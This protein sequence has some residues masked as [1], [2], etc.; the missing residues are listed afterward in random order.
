MIHPHLIEPKRRTGTHLPGP[1]TSV[2]EA[3][4]EHQT[5]STKEVT[6]EF[7]PKEEPHRISQPNMPDNSLLQTLLSRASAPITT[8][9]SQ[10]GSA[11]SE[12]LNNKG[13]GKTGALAEGV[14]NTL[15]DFTSPI[16]LA[17]MGLGPMIGRAA[18]GLLGGA[19]APVGEGAS[20]LMPSVTNFGKIPIPSVI[21]KAAKV[22]ET[23]GEMSPEFTPVGAEEM[24]GLVKP[25]IGSSGIDPL[26][27]VLKQKWAPLLTK[28]GVK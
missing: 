24:Y 3:L 10:V 27:E 2:Q 9:P 11:A 15:S 5:P 6:L 18:S 12:A 21:N 7:G 20:K 14:G 25:S 23:L 1:P 26:E 19:A 28:T 22:G 4:N 17:L 13:W 8:I 16:S